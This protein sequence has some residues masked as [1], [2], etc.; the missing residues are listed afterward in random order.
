MKRIS[1]T[2]HSFEKYILV[3]REKEKRL[4]DG[5]YIY[6]WELFLKELWGGKLF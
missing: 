3:C 4:V 6:P 2:S 1:V 5:I